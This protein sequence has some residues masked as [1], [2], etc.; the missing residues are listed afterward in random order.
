MLKEKEEDRGKRNRKEERC[1]IR[2][3]MRKKEKREKR[4]K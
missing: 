2:F 1:K 4:R 3:I